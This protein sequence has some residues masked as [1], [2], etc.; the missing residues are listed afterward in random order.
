LLDLD[1]LVELKIAILK[2]AERDSI[3]ARIREN[4]DGLSKY[5]PSG[6]KSKIELLNEVL[7]GNK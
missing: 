3:K 5:K 6:Y 2:A 7:G 4:V 1:D